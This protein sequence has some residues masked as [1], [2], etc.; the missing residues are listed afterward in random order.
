MR[1]ATVWYGASGSR[2]NGKAASTTVT[3]SGPEADA[4]E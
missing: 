2:S 4:R 1:Y 3:T